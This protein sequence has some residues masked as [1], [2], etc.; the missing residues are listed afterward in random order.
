[1][2][3]KRMPDCEHPKC[4]EAMMTEIN[5]RVTWEPFDKL[6]QETDTKMPKAWIK[7]WWLGFVAL[8]IPLLTAALGVWSGQQA[9]VLKYAA[10]EELVK[11]QIRI[12][13]LENNVT[14]IQQDLRDIKD[15]M[16]EVL[17]Y[18]RRD[19]GD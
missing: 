9:D 11:S 15:G 19:R 17:K 2:E 8:G 1:M 14:Y 18:V 7:W 10:K 12:E 5:K 16:T 3:G 13:R 6:R 4:H